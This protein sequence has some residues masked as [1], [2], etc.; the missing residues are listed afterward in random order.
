MAATGRAPAGRRV[1]VRGVC[2]SGDGKAKVGTGVEYPEVG[3]TPA[4]VRRV[5]G[6][7]VGRRVEADRSGMRSVRRTWWRRMLL[8][9]SLPILRYVATRKKPGI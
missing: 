4:E 5:T 3:S 1:V 6:A 9:H 2:F 7:R 8:S